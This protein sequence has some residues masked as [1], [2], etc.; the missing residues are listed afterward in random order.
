MT[1]SLIEK[2][3][4]ATGPDRALDREI[5]EAVGWERKYEWRYSEIRYWRLG[6]MSWTREDKDHPPHY[7]ES[8]DAA[9]TL[10]PPESAWAVSHGDPD[11]SGYPRP[12]RATVMPPFSQKQMC[13]A[14]ECHEIPAIAL[15]IAALKVRGIK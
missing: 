3:Q 12:Y 2:L 5:A 7:T 13:D 6:D 11:P 1:S 14:T 10:M 15:C 9:M 4:T 8:L